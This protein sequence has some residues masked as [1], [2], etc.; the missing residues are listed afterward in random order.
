MGGSFGTLSCEEGQ[1]G[2]FARII[3]FLATSRG[4]ST[5]KEKSAA[6]VKECDVTRCECSEALCLASGRVG[7]DPHAAQRSEQA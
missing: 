4:D 1:N 7:D 2:I 6:V 5:R 3:P